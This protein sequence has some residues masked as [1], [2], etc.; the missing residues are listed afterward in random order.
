MTEPLSIVL[1]G[2]NGYGSVYL[3]ALLDET[4]PV[5][6]RIAA[7]V[8]PAPARCARLDELKARGAH[9]FGSLDACYN[10]L[11][12]A[13]ETADLVIVSSPIQWHAPQTCL[14][15]SRGSHV[16]CEKPAAATIDDVDRMRRAQTEADRF[17]AVGFQWSFYPSVQQLKADI[18]AGLFGAP[19]RFKSLCLW[20]RDASY[21]GRNSWA[22]RLRTRDGAMV[23][24]SPVNNAMAHFL[25]HMLY[26]LGDRTEQSAR[27][28]SLTAELYRANEIETFDTAALRALTDDGMEILFYCSHAVPA[29][30]GPMFELEFEHATVTYEGGDAPVIARFVDG[31]TKKY[32]SPESEPQFTKLWT[33]LDAIARKKGQEAIPCG[34]D[35][36]RVHTLCVH[37]VHESM[38]AA[39]DF[40]EEL[41]RETGEGGQRLKWIDRLSSVIEESYRKNQLPTELG[42]HWAR[43]GKVIELK[44]A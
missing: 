17:V 7:L 28:A 25:H 35:A 5:P 30:R 33:C 40:P 37:A 8:D 34:L 22:G 42:A 19:R 15:L 12:R 24:D 21:Y 16:L 39:V 41:V 4:L 27:P 10:A 38:P 3:S 20:P 32:A 2:I 31:R 14:A 6:V 29:D 44:Q 13:G 43:P 18:M 1:A 11:G 23:L 36:A 9:C 26:L